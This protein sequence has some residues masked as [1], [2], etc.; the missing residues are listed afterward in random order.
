MA[1]I[2]ICCSLNSDIICINASNSEYIACEAAVIAQLKD[3]VLIG[4]AALQHHYKQR[5]VVL[6]Y[7]FSEGCVV[8][9]KTAAALI[10][11]MLDNL[12]AT[13]LLIPRMDALCIIPSGIN[14]SDKKLI[15]NLFVRV[16][17][18]QVKFLEIPVCVMKYVSSVYKVASG[19]IL[20][21]GHS[22]T[23]VAAVIDGRINCGCSVA[24]SNVQ[25]NNIIKKA[26]DEKYE[27]NLP[28][29]QVEILRNSC[30][31]LYHNDTT[32]QNVTAFSAS[33]NRPEV[34]N[35]TSRELYAP[36][37]AMYD[38]YVTL[39]KSILNSLTDYEQM[40]I[41]DT[42]IFVSGSQANIGGLDKFLYDQ[43]KIPVTVLDEA[44][45]T[46]IKGARLIANEIM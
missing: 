1:K 6:S 28:L 33:L 12:L 20:D 26:V 35:I 27:I 3:S 18:K 42:G 2:K 13:K 22:N 19:I 43:L 40:L 30:I 10:Q 17:V 25:L 39:I 41:K 14:T 4:T 45:F 29:D 15:Q 31:S 32:T 23:D 5:N 34:Y 11:T 36:V 9:A 37:S 46:A 44:S 24:L 38:N 7:P 16:G 21:L 8:N